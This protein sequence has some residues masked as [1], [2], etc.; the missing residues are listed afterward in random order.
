VEIDACHMGVWEKP[1]QVA[2]ALLRHA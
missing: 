1:Q 2:E